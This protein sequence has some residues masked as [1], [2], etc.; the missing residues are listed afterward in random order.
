M[1]KLYLLRHAKSDWSNLGVSDHDRVLNKRG[2][3]ASTLL[4][5]RFRE[6]GLRPD[7]VVC[8][9]AARARETLDRAMD[10][11]QLDWHVATDPRLYGASPDTILTIIHE[12]G[13]SADSLMLVGHNP[14]FADVAK[15]L[16]GEAKQ[17]MLERL[18]HKVPTGALITLKFDVNSFRDVR[19]QSGVLT[20]FLRPKHE[21]SAA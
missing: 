2:R 14:G 18:R 21:L 16:A 20:H 10:A 4:G 3:K 19:A 5:Y 13:D 11:G 15:A 8:S 6:F 17:G 1:K 9:T 7:T 12:Y